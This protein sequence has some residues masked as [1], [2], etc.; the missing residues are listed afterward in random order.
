MCVVEH[1][2]CSLC[3]QKNTAQLAHSKLTFF[4][5]H[6]DLAGESGE[7]FDA[8]VALKGGKVSEYCVFI[9]FGYNGSVGGV[10]WTGDILLCKGYLRP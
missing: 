5:F 4:G 2:V 1:I 7:R 3:L 10:G 9:W 6:Q 8:A